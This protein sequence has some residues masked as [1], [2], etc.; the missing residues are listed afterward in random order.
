MGVLREEVIDCILNPLVSYGS[1]RSPGSV[2]AKNER[3]CIPYNPT[4]GDVITVLW[5]SNEWLPDRYTPPE[6]Q[7]S[8]W[9]N[10]NAKEAERLLEAWGFVVKE[11]KGTTKLWAYPNDPESRLIPF[12]TPSTRKGNGKGS[13]RAAAQ[14]V[15]VSV[16]DFMKGPPPVAKRA[17]EALTALGSAFDE[18]QPDPLGIGPARRQAAIAEAHQAGAE[19]QSL[20]RK[21]DALTPVQRLAYDALVVDTHSAAEVAL[22]IERGKTV[23]NEILNHLLDK[24]LVTCRMSTPADG[25]GTGRPRLLYRAGTAEIPTLHRA[26]APVEPLPLPAP[27]VEVPMPEEAP[28]QAVPDPVIDLDRASKSEKLFTAT[29]TQWPTGG[30]L[31]QDEEGVYYVARRLVEEGRA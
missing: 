31:I 5:A 29:G 28:V 25:L 26:A 18:K 21:L 20:N 23:T 12:T 8:G 10:L 6:E 19:L 14:A 30:I 4:T 9:I 13:W 16:P 15:G 1:D 11:D 17:M 24:G 2:V 27:A 3:L 22:L 7:V